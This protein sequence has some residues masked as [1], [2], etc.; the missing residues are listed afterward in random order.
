MPGVARA[1]FA[2][3]SQRVC[4]SGSCVNP[5]T[6]ADVSASL[7]ILWA[8]T[9]VIRAT[10][11]RFEREEFQGG[12]E[13]VWEM[14]RKQNYGTTRQLRKQ[15]ERLRRADYIPRLESRIGLAFLAGWSPSSST[16]RPV[17]LHQKCSLA[18]IQRRT[19]ERFIV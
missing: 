18:Y 19:M 10:A 17:S 13:R 15:T 3:K 1:R 8:R 2:V 11:V 16:H 12:R 7:A 6:R 9:T 14:A 4:L 5:V